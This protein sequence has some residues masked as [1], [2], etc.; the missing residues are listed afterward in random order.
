MAYRKHV[1]I[2]F[3]LVGGLWVIRALALCF[4]NAAF[5]ADIAIPFDL[6]GTVIEHETGKP[7]EGAYVIAGYHEAIASPAGSKQW[8]IRTRGATT[9]PDGRFSFPVE[10]L[11]GLSPASI[12]A[13][14]PGY[15]LYVTRYPDED[16]FR[17]QD[18]AAYANR[19]ILLSKQDPKNPSLRYGPDDRFCD[20]AKT[21]ADAA[22][23]IEFLR[24]QLEEMTRLNMP[25]GNVKAVRGAIDRLRAIDSKR[26]RQQNPAEASK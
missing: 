12:G 19:K 18:A 9:G 16:V 14:K 3:R 7:L 10:K 26:A 4:G 2:S 11:D 13:I 20:H 17:K 25:N 21:T 8:C 6:N 23:S 1:M 5:A 15:Y 22:A 24:I